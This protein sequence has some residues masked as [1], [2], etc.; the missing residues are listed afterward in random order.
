[1][2]PVTP[3]E[4]FQIIGEQTVTI[5]KQAQEMARMQKEITELKP[6]EV[7]KDGRSKDN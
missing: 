6:K 5:R 7:K 4:L 1:M 2:N 3:E